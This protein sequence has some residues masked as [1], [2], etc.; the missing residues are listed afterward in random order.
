MIFFYYW[1]FDMA[2]QMSTLNKKTNKLVYMANFDL[3]ICI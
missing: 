3:K 1:D 2:L